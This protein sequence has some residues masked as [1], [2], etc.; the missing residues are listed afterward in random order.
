MIR[1]SLFLLISLLCIGSAH[2]HRYQTYVVHTY[3]DPTIA[4]IVQAELN[5]RQGGSVRMYK[6]KL[7]IRTTP[8]DYRAISA[9]ISQIDTA[10]APLTVSLSVN[11]SLNSHQQGSHIDVGISRQIW[12]NGSYHNVNSTQNNQSNYTARTLSGSSVQ[13]GADTLIGLVGIQPYQKGRHIMARFGTTWI[14]LTDG[15][16]ATPRLLPNGQIS[17][18][19]SQSTSRSHNHLNTTVIIPRGQ[20]SKIGEIQTSDTSYTSYQ[21]SSRQHIMPIWIRVD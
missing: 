19:I 17:L 7:I 14:T 21:S 6:D 2:A 13:I 20:W 10:P 3:G 5:S 18:S 1:P 11:E 15:F 8:T 4:E 9:L 16:K 12:V